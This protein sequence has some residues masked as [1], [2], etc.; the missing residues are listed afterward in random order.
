MHQSLEDTV[1][2]DSGRNLFHSVSQSTIYGSPILLSDFFCH[3]WIFS[4]L[5]LWFLMISTPGIHG[6][7]FIQSHIKSR[8]REVMGHNLV[9]ILQKWRRQPVRHSAWVQFV[10]HNENVIQF[11]WSH[12]RGYHC[13]RSVFHGYAS[14]LHSFNDNSMDLALLC[15]KNRFWHHHRLQDHCLNQGSSCFR[16]Y[17]FPPFFNKY[18]AS[19]PSFVG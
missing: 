15:N 1:L 4:I 10:I 3:S 2:N 9:L 7:G 18:S 5:S 12:H 13:S 8:R 16:K 17:Y 14:A 19:T 6:D 11:T